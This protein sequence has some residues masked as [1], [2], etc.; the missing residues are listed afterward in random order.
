MTAIL[1]GFLTAHVIVLGRYFDWMIANGHAAILETTYAV[2][3][4]EDDPVTPYLGSFAAQVGLAVILFTVAVFQRSRFGVKR[5][6]AASLAALALPL[7]M[8][9]FT[10]TGFHHI[11]HDVMSAR[12]L[13]EQAL[14]T[15]LT[16]NLPLHAI[17]AAI[18][19]AAATMLLFT[20]PPRQQHSIETT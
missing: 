1:S 3:R 8:T 5:M 12:D 2:F 6:V 10:V 18:Y 19:V 13:S 9:I 15:W 11:E 20:D 17:A 7:T 16:L 14:T 4:R